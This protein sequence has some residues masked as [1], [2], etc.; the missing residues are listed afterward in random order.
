[1]SNPTPVMVSHDQHCAFTDFM[2]YMGFNR[3]RALRFIGSAEIG[4]SEFSGFWEPLNSLSS[5]ALRQMVSCGSISSQEHRFRA[6]VKAA[7]DKYLNVE[8]SAN[9]YRREDS[10]LNGRARGMSEILNILGIDPLD[11][12]TWKLPA[13]QGGKVHD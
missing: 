3:S 12:T 2:E 13:P 8:G 7:V 1:M 9:Y 4:E 5:T 10:H 11:E 6:K